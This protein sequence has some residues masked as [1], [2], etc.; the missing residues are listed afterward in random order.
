[1]NDQNFKP[2]TLLVHDGKKSHSKGAVV[3]PIYQNSLFSLR[4]ETPHVFR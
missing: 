4:S 2:E 1:M 3:P